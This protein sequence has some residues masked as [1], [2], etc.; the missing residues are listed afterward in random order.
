MTKI[1]EVKPIQIQSNALREAYNIQV[2]IRKTAGFEVITQG[3][4]FA[5]GIL[6]YVLVTFMSTE[7][8]VQTKLALRLDGSVEVSYHSV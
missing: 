6:E 2:N 4:G 8:S 3:V 1:D 5:N 7:T